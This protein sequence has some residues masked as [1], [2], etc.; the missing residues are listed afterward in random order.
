KYFGSV[1]GGLR[2]V[3][4]R[5]N[6]ALVLL[7]S[8]RAAGAAA[9]WRAALDLHP[10][11]VPPPAGVGGAALRPDDH[12]GLGAAPP[13]LRPFG[14]P[15]A[16]A[17]RARGLWRLRK[18][19]EAREVLAASLDH[20]PTALGLHL[21]MAH[22]WLRD[23]SDPAAAERALLAVLALEPGHDETRHNL[24]VLRRQN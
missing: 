23:G 21:L 22:A 18:Y 13:P 12:H 24:S 17:L 15:R 5:H 19:R 11:V 1:D 2:G 8:G 10:A 4:A 6:L 3:K 14:P 16:A 9:Q 20:A 7:E